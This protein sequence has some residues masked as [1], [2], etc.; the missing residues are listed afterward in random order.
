[1]TYVYP[2]HIE[3]CTLTDAGLHHWKHKR[4]KRKK[5]KVVYKV[6]G[7]AVDRTYFP[8]YRFNLYFVL[9]ERESQGSASRPP[10]S[11]TLVVADGF[12]IDFEEVR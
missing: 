8:H 9:L 4:V 12:N 3:L 7:A 2:S 10:G 11:Q 1:M 6:R 5:G